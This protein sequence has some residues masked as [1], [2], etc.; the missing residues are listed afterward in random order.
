MPY[1]VPSRVPGG[2]YFFTLRLAD[3]SSSLLV[4]HVDLLRQ[5][6][7][8]ARQNH[9]FDIRAAVVLPAKLHMIWTL[10]NDDANYGIRWRV[11]KTTFSR[12]VAPPD[13]DRQTVAMVRKR[14]KGIWQRRYWEHL[15]RDQ[16]D[17]DLHEH[18][19]IHA[20]VQ[21]GLVAQPMDW[22][23]SSLHSRGHGQT[24]LTAP[25]PIVL[26]RPVS[27]AATLF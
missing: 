8:V 5:S 3:P 6:V 4:D 13:R 17:Y 14:E 12:H 11:I 1:D 2:T 23:F 24:R 27:S 18:L 9:P 10:P 22:A 20:P 16:A 21:E 25:P 15:I 26:N 7:R 19:I